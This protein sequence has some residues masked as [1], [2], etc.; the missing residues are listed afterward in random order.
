MKYCP[1]C[2]ASGYQWPKT[3]LGVDICRCGN[4]DLTEVTEG[5]V[6]VEFQSLIESQFTPFDRH[7]MEA[8]AVANEEDT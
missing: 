2:G 3:K 1:E 8:L 7:V 4:G 6:M 5:L